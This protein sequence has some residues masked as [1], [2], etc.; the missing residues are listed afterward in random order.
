MSMRNRVV[1]SSAGRMSSTAASRNPSKSCLVG[2]WPF[3]GEGRRGAN[4]MPSI[5]VPS[6]AGDLYQLVIGDVRSKFEPIPIELIL[7]TNEIA[8]L[9]LYHGRSE[10]H[11]SELQ[12]RGHLVC[13]LLLEKKNE[14]KQIILSDLLVTVDN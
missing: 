9:F 8:K 7:T 3:M 13:R 1:S 12:S 10:E 11:T 6:A 2:L 5:L 14:N 4:F